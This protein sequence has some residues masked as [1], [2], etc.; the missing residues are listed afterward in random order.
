MTAVPGAGTK[1]AWS[2][3]GGSSDWYRAMKRTHVMDDDQGFL[4]AAVLLLV[5]EHPASG[6]KLVKDLGALGFGPIERPAVYLA[7]AQLMRDGLVTGWDG[8]RIGGPARSRYSITDQ[9]GCALRSWMGVVRQERDCL[10]RVLH[11]YRAAGRADAP[12]RRDR[13]WRPRSTASTPGG[14]SHLSAVGPAGPGPGGA[15][16]EQPLRVRFRVVPGGSPTGGRR[17]GAP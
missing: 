8:S 1:R 14:G 3:L 16:E 2:S 6:K 10:D 12:A 17:P 4:L 7:L 15:G 9:G 11:R 13:A 5:W